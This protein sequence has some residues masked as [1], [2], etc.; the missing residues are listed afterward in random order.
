MEAS[1]P[2]H[3]SKEESMKQLSEMLDVKYPSIVENRKRF[4]LGPAYEAVIKTLE[5]VRRQ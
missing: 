1:L 5:D 3:L 4:E 2:P